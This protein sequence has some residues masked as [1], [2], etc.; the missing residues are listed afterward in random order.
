M[1]HVLL[2]FQF[3]YYTVCSSIMETLKVHYSFS[4]RENLLAFLSILLY[5]Y[6]NSEY[7]VHWQREKVLRH[8]V[9]LIVKVFEKKC[10]ITLDGGILNAS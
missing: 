10:E 8:Y 9:N 5:I 7:F 4:L 3:P 6:E 1:D 2:H